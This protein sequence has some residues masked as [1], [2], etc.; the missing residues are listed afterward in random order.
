MLMA[1]FLACGVRLPPVQ[2]DL[3]AQHPG[4]D[5]IE[6]LAKWLLD[7]VAHTK[8]NYEDTLVLQR[9]MGTKL[10]KSAVFC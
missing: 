2:Q 10:V 1:T 4:G 6:E 3:V 5:T 8:I 9:L 7:A